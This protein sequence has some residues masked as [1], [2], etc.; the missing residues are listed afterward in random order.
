M[1]SIEEFAA[2]LVD[3][4]KAAR[5]LEQQRKDAEHSV[6]RAQTEAERIR[7][8]ARKDRDDAR[9]EA[10]EDSLKHLDRLS[11]ASADHEKKLAS[12]KG[13]HDAYV[14]NARAQVQ[15]ASETLTALQKDIAGARETRDALNTELGKLRA[16]F[17]DSA[18]RL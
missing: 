10:Q 5:D 8:D 17:A 6:V 16:A 7:T 13:E 11:K 2:A 1:K 4:V 18:A 12:E 9:R 15:T 14:S 3:A